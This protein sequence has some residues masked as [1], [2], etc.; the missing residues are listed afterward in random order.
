MI[1]TLATKLVASWSNLESMVLYLGR[2]AHL[3]AANPS[4]QTGRHARLACQTQLRGDR[5]GTCHC[6]RQIR[7]TGYPWPSGPLY[8]IIFDDGRDEKPPS[9]SPL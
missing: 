2:L 9:L 6:T 3:F 7:R 5:K 4:V 1:D 8:D